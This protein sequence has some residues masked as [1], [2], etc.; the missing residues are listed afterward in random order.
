[1]ALFVFG[2][3]SFLEGFGS[4]LVVFITTF[5]FLRLNFQNLFWFLNAMSLAISTSI[6]S[7][8]HDEVSFNEMSLRGDV[9]IVASRFEERTRFADID[10]PKIDFNVAW[11]HETHFSK[12]VAFSSIWTPPV[13]FFDDMRFGGEASF[14]RTS[15]KEWLTAFNAELKGIRKLLPMHGAPT[16]MRQ[17]EGGCRTLRKL[18]AAN[19]NVHLEHQWHRCELIARRSG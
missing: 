3:Q 8:F 15:E 19:G 13:Q 18:A 17:L 10:W 14:P 7:H 4:R 16:E 11:G 12:E 1:M 2:K 5:R 6:N 9:E